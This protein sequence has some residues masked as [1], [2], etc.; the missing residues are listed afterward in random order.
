MYNYLNII[1]KFTFKFFSLMIFIE[2]TCFEFPCV[3]GA[4]MTDPKP[5]LERNLSLQEFRL[6][7]C[8]TEFIRCWFLPC[9]A[10]FQLK[11][12]T[13]FVKSRLC[14]FSSKLLPVSSFQTMGMWF[15]LQ[16]N[17]VL[18]SEP[19]SS[20]LVLW[21]FRSSFPKFWVQYV[22]NLNFMLIFRFKIDGLCFR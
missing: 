15:F 16:N 14:F 5:H 10:W 2:I 4:Q 6:N 7:T 9:A 12:R 18:I 8:F 17:V 3:A 19:I 11:P 13:A 1:Y 20:S 21:V 22:S